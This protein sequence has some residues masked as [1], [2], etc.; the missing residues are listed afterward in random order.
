VRA[1]QVSRTGPPEVL[2]LVDLPVPA[3]LP[4]TVLVDMAIA[5]V[6][7]AD[8]L[9]RSGRLDAPLPF[10]P[11]VDVAGRVEAVG[12]GVD[13]G[14]LGRRVVVNTGSFGGYAER[15]RVPAGDAYE[16]PDGLS[17]EQAVGVFQ[18]GRTALRV[19]K[20]AHVTPGESVLVDAAAG[21]TGSLLVQLAKAAGARVVAA[22]GSASKA[23]LLERLGA[24]A[25]VDYSRPEWTTA[26]LDATGG[27][28]PDVTF[29]SVGG[30]IGRAA[31]LATAK[32]G[33]RFVV[34]GAASGATAIS[35]QEVLDGGVSVLAT[36]RLA[37][38]D[39]EKAARENSRHVLDE[40]AAGRLVAEIGGRFPLE[41][42]REA[43]ALIESRQNVGRLLLFPEPPRPAAEDPRGERQE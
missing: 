31:W 26:L 40:A 5:G 6:L 16:I 36:S 7:L 11:G 41:R 8:V 35:S 22:A 13:G 25:F 9:F 33:G 39:P 1:I 15:V 34:Y 23:G 4:G 12:D 2:E 29:E 14:L 18:S 30:E 10:V 32:H 21:S 3:V 42:A 19:L 27:R 38:P 24:D 20:C 17:W 43:H 28:G 37:G